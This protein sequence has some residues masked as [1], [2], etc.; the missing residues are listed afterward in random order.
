M[1]EQSMRKAWSRKQSKAVLWDNN[2]AQFDPNVKHTL[3]HVGPTM[4]GALTAL[5]KGTLL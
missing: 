4:G 3:V 1:R 2:G 5:Y